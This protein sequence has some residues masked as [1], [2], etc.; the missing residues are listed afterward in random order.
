MRIVSLLPSATETVFALGCGDD[1][2]GVTFECDFPAEARTRR[3]VSTSALP[4]GLTPAEIDAEV[5]A[6]V[7]AGDDLYRLDAGALADLDVDVVLTQDL[8]AVCAVDVDVVDAALAH[9]GCSAKVV[10]I[11]PHTLDEVISS[12]ATVG[13]A[14]GVPSEAAALTT[15]A[16]DRLDRLAEAVDGAARPEVLVLEW[17]DPAFTAGHWVPDLVVA[18]GGRPVLAHPGADSRRVAWSDVAAA[19]TDVVVVAPCG[20]HLDDA[21]ALGEGVLAAG[22]LPAGVEVWAVD[23]DA[24]VVRPGPRLVDGAE[25]FGAILHPDR[26]G[27]PD[28][29]RARR[30]A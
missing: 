28:P 1:L 4:E 20:F 12:F 10:T 7:A 9:L 17:T 27:A 16:R 22:R 13:A 30:L 21:A 18:G 3:I 11:D 29:A 19:R 14:L 25:L 2:V 23:A 24:Y 15:A 26:V 5:S 8:C 6:R